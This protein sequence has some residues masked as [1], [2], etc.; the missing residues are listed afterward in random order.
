MG[1]IANFFDRIHTWLSN[2]SDDIQ[3]FS[4]AFTHRL[5]RLA[6][7]ITRLMIAGILLYIVESL[8]PGFAKKYPVIFSWY[9]GWLQFC[10]FAISAVFQFLRT[11]FT[12]NWSDFRAEY[13]TAYHLY[14]DQFLNWVYSLHF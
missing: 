3:A 5:R 4:V 7:N 8:C 12:G 2:H 10:E 13:F 11:L 1:Y 6:R 14:L 9:T